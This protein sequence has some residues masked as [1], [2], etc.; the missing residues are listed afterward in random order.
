[1]IFF[2]SILLYGFGLFF[3]INEFFIKSSPDSHRVVGILIT[4]ILYTVKMVNRRRF[5]K[6]KEEQFELE[7]H[8]VVQNVF[9]YDDTK[10]ASFMQGIDLVLL[11][12]PKKALPIFEELQRD[13]GT[14]EEQYAV[15][16]FIGECY[17][18]MKQ[19]EKEIALCQEMTRIDAKRVEAWFQMGHSYLMLERYEEAAEAL[20]HAVPLVQ[21]KRMEDNVYA[22]LASVY[23]C[24]DRYIEAKKYID[25]AYLLNPH[26][27]I[28]SLKEQI[29]EALEYPIADLDGVKVTPLLKHIVETIGYP[30]RILSEY[31]SSEELMQLY[32]ET[33]QRGRRQG[34]VPVFLSDD[35]LYL[36]WE[37]IDA[38]G[39]SFDQYIKDRINRLGPIGDGKKISDQRFRELTEPNEEYET[40]ALEELTSEM[41]GGE[42]QDDLSSLSDLP[43]VCLF[44]VPVTRPWEVLLYLSGGAWEEY[45]TLE[46]LLAICKYWYEKYHVLPASISEEGID[47]VLPE[48]IPEEEAFEVAKEIFAFCEDSLEILT[49]SGTLGE[50]ADRIRKSGV[51]TLWWD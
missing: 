45:V 13:A 33:L 1:M 8:D 19:Y 18:I 40:Y 39:I 36:W 28:R 48:P 37:E 6:E 9:Q 44:E 12:K 5:V 41:C 42:K 15:K 31:T 11:H 21:E 20:E 4:L 46:E 3:L 43:L 50:L 38:A 25:K 2:L 27:E 23:V 51:W 29:E 47:F 35:A 16:Y 49:E 14:I 22:T 24:A 10:Y 32:Q 30:H 34:F 17:Y 7:Y 26:K